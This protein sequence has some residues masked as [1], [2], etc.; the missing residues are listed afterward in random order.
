M[1]LRAPPHQTVWKK[2]EGMRLQ[3]RGARAEPALRPPEQEGG[4]LVSSPNY[5]VRRSTGLNAST[6]A[7]PWSGLEQQ[8]GRFLWNRSGH[9]AAP[10]WFDNTPALGTAPPPGLTSYL[11]RL[12]GSSH[13]A[14][15]LL[16]FS[17]AHPPFALAAPCAQHAC[18]PEINIHHPFKSCIRLSL[19]N[20]HC[21]PHPQPHFLNGPCCLLFQSTIH[22]S[23]HKYNH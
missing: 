2:L 12:K 14:S 6:L 22:F 15:C 9:S 13:K 23:T 19:P 7:L 11:S 18:P 8:P 17:H 20:A 4:G 21:L 1:Q 3:P 5:N 10:S 16:L